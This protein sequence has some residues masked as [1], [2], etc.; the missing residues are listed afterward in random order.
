LA[1]FQCHANRSKENET[2]FELKNNLSEV[3]DSYD[4]STDRATLVSNILAAMR[5]ANSLRVSASIMCYKNDRYSI[6]LYR[7]WLMGFSNS[8]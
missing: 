7:S 5:K 2:I 3:T 4:G 6:N 8:G 1:T